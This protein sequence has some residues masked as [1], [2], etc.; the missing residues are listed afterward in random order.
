MISDVNKHR[1]FLGQDL[2]CLVSW[3]VLESWCIHRASGKVTHTQTKNKNYIFSF[4][5][6]TSKQKF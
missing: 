3:I 2:D 6:G 5:L 4:R 1:A